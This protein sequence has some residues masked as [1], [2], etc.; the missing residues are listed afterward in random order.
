MRRTT[1]LLVLLSGLWAGESTANTEVERLVAEA[2]K[3]WMAS[4]GA[5]TLTE[6][7]ARLREAVT[8]H[9][10]LE[11]R[12][13][14]RAGENLARHARGQLEEALKLQ[15]AAPCLQPP[16]R[17]CL[18]AEAEKRVQRDAPAEALQ[19]AILLRT[20]GDRRFADRFKAILAKEPPLFESVATA[21]ELAAAKA[22][23]LLDAFAK[24]MSGSSSGEG[25]AAVALFFRNDL[26]GYKAMLEKMRADR[27]LDP[28]NAAAIA[29]HVRDP[30]LFAEAIEQALA[31]TP[32]HPPY[33]LNFV[34]QSLAF[35]DMADEV[36]ALAA[37]RESPLPG[38]DYRVV[39]LAIIAGK[40][41]ELDRLQEIDRSLNSAGT[42]PLSRTQRGYWG[43]A[44]GWAIAGRI[45]E[46]EA[47]FR[48]QLDPEWGLDVLAAI[49]LTHARAGRA[50]DAVDV[51][52][53]LDQGNRD[54]RTEVV[55]AFA[56]VAAALR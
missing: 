24:A 36:R 3:A 29:M 15:S 33:R 52:L 18:F 16:H 22:D 26:N 4:R 45:E 1:M 34:I 9:D 38:A 44:L 37:R 32:P 21:A 6:R 20:T 7:I 39:A 50:R 25:A 47:V 13:A 54:R 41:Q 2:N 23:D 53:V 49:A 43:I 35:A 10:A 42:D 55:R 27:R 30:A 12:A 56:E 28:I 5:V 17:A 8:A 40:R 11:K 51:L 31:F 46:A 48:A 19:L 14:K